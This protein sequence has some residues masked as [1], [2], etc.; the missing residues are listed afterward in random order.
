[1]ETVRD[2]LLHMSQVHG[3]GWDPPEGDEGV[4]ECDY[5]DAFHHLLEVMVIQRGPG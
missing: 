3:D 1:V 2:L 5:W 4:G